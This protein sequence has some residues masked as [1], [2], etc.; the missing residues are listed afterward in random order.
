[1]GLPAGTAGLSEETH[2]HYNASRTISPV[3]D[4]SRYSVCHSSWVEFRLASLRHSILLWGVISSGGAGRSVPPCHD[5]A[6][7]VEAAATG[8]LWGP[9]GCGCGGPVRAQAGDRSE[10]EHHQS[11][12]GGL[13][14]RRSESIFSTKVP[15]GPTRRTYPSLSRGHSIPWPGLA[16]RVYTMMTLSTFKFCVSTPA[17]G[18]KSAS[19]QPERRATVVHLLKVYHCPGRCWPVDPS[20]TWML[21][22]SPQGH[23]GV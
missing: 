16:S 21:R 15:V 20:R 11:R 2:K 3:P 7:S 23:Y 19:S 22:L 4:I 14:T 5:P 6:A 10:P 9:A 13:V 1:M 18:F 17:S 12:W 8:L